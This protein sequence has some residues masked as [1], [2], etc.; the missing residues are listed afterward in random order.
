[1]IHQHLRPHQRQGQPMPATTMPVP[2]MQVSKYL[3]PLASADNHHLS[4]LPTSALLQAHSTCVHAPVHS[5]PPPPP[6]HPL[7]NEDTTQHEDG[8]ATGWDKVTS[9]HIED[10]D[11]DTTRDT[12]RTQTQRNKDKTQ[13]GHDTTGTR[14]DMRHDEDTDTTQR[15]H[16]TTRTQRDGDTTQ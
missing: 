3:H 13:Q 1:M 2:G 11:M 5:R 14:H 7:S 6:S 12:T 4:V 8:N 15:G 10:G 16:N 9:R